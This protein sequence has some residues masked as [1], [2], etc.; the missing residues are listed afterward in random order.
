MEMR[1]HFREIV[2][3]MGLLEEQQSKCCD[4]SLVQCHVLT[5]IAEHEGL[6]VNDLAVRLNLDKSTTSRHISNLVK[7]GLVNR[8]E[9]ANDR[10]YFTLSLTK[11]GQT[12][13]KTINSTMDGYYE[14]LQSKLSDDEKKKIIEALSIVQGAMDKMTCC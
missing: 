2:R 1:K 14:E 11:E 10:R 13:N 7:D 6:S 9:N 8:L 4:L 5:E 12:I 3:R